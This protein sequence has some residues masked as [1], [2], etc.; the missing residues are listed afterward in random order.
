VLQASCASSITDIAD[1]LVI[2]EDGFLPQHQVM[3][4]FVYRKSAWLSWCWDDCAQGWTNAN[5][6]QGWTNANCAQGWTN[7]NCAQGWTNANCAQGWAITN[8]AQGW[9]ANC[10]QGWTNA[11]RAQ[12]WTNTNCAQVEQIQTVH[13]DE[14]IQTAYLYILR[15]PF[16]LRSKAC[17]RK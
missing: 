6:A 5:C 1:T 8:C 4:W 14:Q 9:T 10:A 2:W 17:T 7:T 3:A 16:T 15:V 11:N 13:R 12:G